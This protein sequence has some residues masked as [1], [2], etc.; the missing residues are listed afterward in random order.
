MFKAYTILIIVMSVITFAAFAIDKA[1]SSN[2][3]NSRMPEMVLLSLMTFG[4]S[5]G[6]MIGMYV[7]RHKTNIAT[8]LHFAITVWVSLAVQVILFIMF[9]RTHGDQVIACAVV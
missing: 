7:L 2:E 4:G 6:G 5:F 8:K 1:R 3:A 9:C